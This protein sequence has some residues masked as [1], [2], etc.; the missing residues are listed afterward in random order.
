MTR[1]RCA[2]NHP[3]FFL[4]LESGF[5]RIQAES[6]KQNPPSGIRRGVRDKSVTVL[7]KFDDCCAQTF[8]STRPGGGAKMNTPTLRKFN[9][10]VFTF[11]SP[12]LRLSHSL[13]NLI[14][15]PNLAAC[16]GARLACTRRFGPA[17]PPRVEAWHRPAKDRR[18]MS[19]GRLA[20]GKRKNVLLLATRR[21]MLCARE[22]RIPCAVTT[23]C[24][25]IG[26]LAGCRRDN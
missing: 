25:V 4:L 9:V 23:A 8:F 22:M 7:L 19:T 12:H 17:P 10:G 1:D 13:G 2:V 14:E 6:A 11:R 24:L 18:I 3:P 26:L 21:A 15:N 16:E 5:K 20:P